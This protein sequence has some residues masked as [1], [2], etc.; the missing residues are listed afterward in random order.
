MER[1]VGIDVGA[2]TLKLAELVRE[3]EVIRLARHAV[4]P[5]GKEPGP[6]LLEVLNGWQWDGV[7]SAVATGRL[8]RQLALARLPTKQALLRGFR[9]SHGEQPAT[10]VSIGSRGI[11]VLEIREAGEPV[12]RESSRCAQGTGNFLRQLVERFGLSVEEA[13]SRAEAVA[14]AAPLSGRCPVILKTDMTHLANKGERQERILAGLLDAIAESAEVLVKPR[15]SPPRVLLTGGVVRAKRIREHFRTFLERNGMALLDVD[16][17]QA[18]VLEAI[19]CALHAALLVPP[20]VPLENLVQPAPEARIDVLPPLRG[21]L[22]RVR[23]MS[24]PALPAANGLPHDVV[25]GFD[26]GSTGSKVVALDAAKEVPLWEG[27]VRTSGDP[28][29]AAQALMRAFLDGPAGGSTVRALGATGSGREIV[30]SLMSVCYGPDAVFV[31]NEIAAHARGALEYDPRVDTIFEIGGQDAKYIRLAGGRV[32]DAAMNEAC[33]A[34]TGSFIEEQGRRFDG[35]E[36]VAALGKIAVSSDGSA[37]LGQHCSIFM[38]EVIDEAVAAGIPRARIVAGLYESVIANYLNRVKGSRSVGEVIFCQ[39]M[40]FASDALAAAVAR[41]TGAE[42]IV[43]PSPGTVGALG[44]ALLA[45]DAIPVKSRAA[46]DASRFLT[47]RVESKDAFVCKSTTGCGGGGNKCRIDRLTTLVAKERLRFTW[48]GS[49]SLYD[50]GTR[51]KKLPDG[52]PH[53]FRERAEL[54]AELS[55]GLSTPRGGTR[56]ALTDDFQLKGMFPFFATFLHGLGLDLAVAEHAD[57]AALKRGIEGAN[58][59]FCA[60]MQQYHGA[61]ATLA[62][63]G[64]DLLFTPMIRE[65]PRVA[66]ERA[67]QLCPVVQGSPDVLGWDLGPNVRD[68]MISPVIDVGP[69]PLDAP[70]FVESCRRLASS[71]GVRRKPVFRDAFHRARGEQLA[72]DERLIDLGRAA[73]DRCARDGLVPVVVLGRTY[74]IHDDVLNSNVPA[75]LRDQGAVAIPVDCYPVGEGAPVFANMYWGH[76]QRI[77]RAAWQVRRTRGVYALFASNYS[78][79]PDSFTHHLVAELM[80]GKPFA[81]IETDGHA[82]DAGTKTR[83]EAFLHCV[84]EHAAAPSD[85]CPARPADRLTVRS[86]GIR[87]IAASG[88]RVLIPTMGDAAEALA[89]ALRGMDV[90]AEVLPEPGPEALQRGRR[91]TSGKECLPTILTLGSLLHRL[92]RGGPDER[93]AF[94]MPGS[95]GPCRFGAYKELHQLVLDRLGF[96]ERVRIWAPPFGD[97][98]QGVPPAFGALVLAGMCATDLL[99]DMLHDVRPRETRPGASDAIYRRFLRTLVRLIERETSGDVS[100]RK[101][102]VESTTGRIWGIPEVIRRAGEAFAGVRGPQ[103]LPLVLVVGEIYLRNVASANGRVVEALERRGIRSRVAAVTEFMQYSDWIGARLRRRSLGERIDSWVRRRI[104]ASCHVAAAEPMGW[105]VAP[106]VR[107]VVR[108]AGRYVRDAL[109]C[110]TVLTVGAALNAWRARE[111]DAVLSVGPLECMPNKLAESQLVHAGEQ[112]EL[113][114]LTLS[115]NGDPIDPEPL[116]GFAIEVHARHRARSDR[117]RAPAPG[118]PESVAPIP[119]LSPE[120]SA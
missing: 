54:V 16:P 36:D 37:A 11:G 31:L 118:E 58:V 92:E 82:G 98:F 14:E 35:V 10:I 6:H 83:V 22:A 105:G 24:R 32:V 117:R 21:A 86:A 84:R 41:Q 114:S 96:G 18:L 5:H 15:R 112:E 109:E 99:R 47:A 57:R 80:D 104:E 100:G 79:G 56:I 113:L 97:Y 12:W 52:T 68:R 1:F 75:I 88:A 2:E 55:R 91:H 34:G 94:F 74:T 78:C 28:V 85:R 46:L 111:V 38:A 3:D 115:L 101:V 95:D 64:A 40:P 49:C 69:G 107:D 67:S 61:M 65:I 73:L 50:K 119:E 120:G 89:A 23:R 110:E 106:H 44:I 20:V 25:L 76:A 87:E 17:E 19:G 13:A 51:T 42:V 48:G 72:F 30:G 71:L 63:R 81:V 4:V 90:P 116:D 53:P 33:S 9:F 27:Y 77:M 62:E 39:G 7:S 102:L 8:G 108:A 70:V 103:E 43:P 93:Y 45:C 59:P 26:V 29:G 66:G 60:P